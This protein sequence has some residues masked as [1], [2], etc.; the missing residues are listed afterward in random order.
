[1]A[2]FSISM[3]R[4]LCKNGLRSRP[5][6]TDKGKVTVT[7]PSDSDEEEEEEEREPKVNLPELRQSFQIQGKLAEIGAVM[8]LKFGCRRVIVDAYEH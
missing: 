1:M 6:K 3:L 8:G 5:S 4:R 2:L 7:V